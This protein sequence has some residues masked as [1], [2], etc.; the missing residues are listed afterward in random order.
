M[1]PN[2]TM[3]SFPKIGAITIMGGVT[4]P[5]TWVTL[6]V[7]VMFTFLLMMITVTLYALGTHKTRAERA[8]VRV[9]R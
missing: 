2:N 8:R 9:A 1:V 7:F 5:T 4:L 3:M 6:R